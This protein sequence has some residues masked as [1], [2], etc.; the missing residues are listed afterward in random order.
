MRARDLTGETMLSLTAN[1]ARSL[2]TILGIVIGIVS[3]IVMISIGDATKASITGELSS[4]GSNLIMVTPRS[5]APGARD[6]TLADAE[7]IATVP[8]VAAVAPVSD[9]AVRRDRRLQQRQRE[10]HRSNGVVRRGQ[11]HRDLAGRVVH[12]RR[13]RP[14]RE[15]RGAGLQDRGR[16]V[17]HRVESRGAT[18]SH[19]QGRSSPWAVSP[20]RRAPR[21][22]RTPTRPRTSR[23]VR[24]ASTSAGPTG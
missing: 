4:V 20:S 9:G 10:R 2:L 14:R 23:S 1:T 17:R 12:R 6:L 18:R 7:A 11:E 15:G 8:G 22:C 13:R 19:R 3:V 16:P 5:D 24:R 21:A